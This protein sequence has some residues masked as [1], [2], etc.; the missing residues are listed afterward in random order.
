MTEG[1]DLRRSL[2]SLAVLGQTPDVN[3]RPV[4]LRV[5]VDLFV[6]K[7]YHSP[8]EMLHFEEIIQR[9]LD[10]A[11]DETRLIV[12]D[13]LS[14]HP[15]TPRSLFDRF[16]AERGLTASRVL[17]HA[18]IAPD[19]VL[20]AACWGTPD[21]ALAVACRPGLDLAAS[22]ALAERPE[23]EILL[24][25]AENQS[26]PLDRTLVQYLV[27]RARGDEEFSRMLLRR[28]CEPADLAPLFLLASSEQRAAIIGSARRD[29]LGPESR[30]P[31][32]GGDEAAALTRVERALLASDQDSFEVALAAAL[33]LPLAETWALIDD[34]RGEPLA[35]ALAAIGASPEFAA[36]VFI[37]SG[38]AIG[39]SVMAVRTLTRVVEDL[40]M[41]TA[42]RIV[43]A[44]TGV[45][46]RSSRGKAAVE[47][48]AGKRRRHEGE[49]RH[50][51]PVVAPLQR[52]L[53]GGRTH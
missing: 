46:V 30:R 15:A 38:P 44:M 37:L 19:I 23:R 17:E 2:E 53:L 25:L 7:T 39:H 40:P 29:D 48:D 3:I 1:D 27:R 16:L 20:A 24:A 41:R 6:R 31:R 49:A 42:C 36:R 10:Q 28:A 18:A 45:P 43:T 14:R 50:I 9:L 33:K 51:H 34:P 4:L 8:A 12:A 21:M 22:R 11:D 13:K 52:R 26:A 47:Q 35:L 5:L 32:L